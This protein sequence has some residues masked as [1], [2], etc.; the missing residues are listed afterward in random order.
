M[1][2]I[3]FESHCIFADAGRPGKGRTLPSNLENRIAWDRMSKYSV[4]SFDTISQKMGRVHVTGQE[5]AVRDMVKFCFANDKQKV[6]ACNA[7]DMQKPFAAVVD[8]RRLCESME[9]S[10]MDPLLQAQANIDEAVRDSVKLRRLT[11]SLATQ[12]TKR[13]SIKIALKK[14]IFH[15]ITAE[16]QEEATTTTEKGP[17]DDADQADN[18]FLADE[19]DKLDADVE[20]DLEELAGYGTAEELNEWQNLEEGH[21]IIFDEMSLRKRGRFAISITHLKDWHP[22]QLWEAENEENAGEVCEETVAETAGINEAEDSK[23]EMLS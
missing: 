21:V 2:T 9:L 7:V 23:N 10:G 13:R 22:E 11:P 12:K 14:Q 5:I 18:K 16:E 3:L 4:S 6:G 20:D 8:A 15:E 1:S 17:D 19:A